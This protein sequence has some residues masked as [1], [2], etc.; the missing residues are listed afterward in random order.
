MAFDTAS[1]TQN[2]TAPP[3]YRT[4]SFP[5]GPGDVYIPSGGRFSAKNIPLYLYI[6]FAYKITDN[7]EQVLLPQL[8]RWVTTDRFDIQAKVEGNPTKDQMRLMMQA[9]LADRFRLAVHHEMRQLPVYALLVDQPGKLGPLFRKH[10]DEV[11]CPTTPMV[12]SPAPMAQPQTLDSRFPATCGGIVPMTPSTPGRLRAGARNVPMDL[13][14]SSLTGG[15]SGLELPIWDRTGLTGNFD[16]AIEFAPHFD[17]P[18]PLGPNF[19]P[20]PTGPT[21]VQALREQLGLKLESR[22]GPVEVL[23]IDSMEKTP[24]AN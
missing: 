20:D 2:T 16:F 3:A 23:V 21:F 24:T 13:I 8:P 9:L 5:L 18:S 22:K 7:Q 4:F 1:V 10:V 11:P 12:P 17:G 15:V 19:R 6:Y 14:A